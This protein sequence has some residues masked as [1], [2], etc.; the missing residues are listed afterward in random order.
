MKA[1]RLSIAFPFPAG[2]AGHV[3]VPALRPEPGGAAREG[4][5]QQSI[6]QQTVRTCQWVEVD[7][8]LWPILILFAARFE[9]QVGDRCG[10]PERKPRLMSDSATAKR[11]FRGSLTGIV[12]GII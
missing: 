1:R 6:A 7:R 9:K 10:N 2:L 8:G 11:D 4:R 3:P 12:S 5:L